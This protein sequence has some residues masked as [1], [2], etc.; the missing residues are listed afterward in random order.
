M[1][2]NSK[3]SNR[4]MLV[5]ALAMLMTFVFGSAEACRDQGNPIS[6]VVCSTQPN[7][8]STPLCH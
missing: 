2:K 4:K 5:L 3:K 8:G 1:A 7:G 6:T